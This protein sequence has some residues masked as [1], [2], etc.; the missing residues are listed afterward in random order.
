MACHA[1]VSVPASY[2]GSRTTD[3]ADSLFARSAAVYVANYGYGYGAVGEAAVCP[4]RLM[5]LFAAGVAD[6][7]TAG[8]AWRMAKQEYVATQGRFGSYDEKVPQQAIFYGLPMYRVEGAQAA[9]APLSVTAAVELQPDPRTGS[10]AVP[11]QTVATVSPSFAKRT[12]GDGSTYQVA[13]AASGPDGQPY[14][15]AEAGAIVLHGYPIQPKVITEVT[16]DGY[17]ARGA[18]IESMSSVPPVD[19]TVIDD[20]AYARAIVDLAANEPEVEPGSVIFPTAFQTVT[21]TSD[22]ATSTDRLLLFPGQLTVDGPDATQ[23]LFTDLTPTVYYVADEDDRA[24]DRTR[25]QILEST[26]GA[27]GDVIRFRVITRDK[28]ADG[29]DG[30]GV[31][32]IVVLY[33]DRTNP[34]WVGAD[35]L[36]VGATDEWVGARCARRTPAAATSCRSS[37]GPAMSA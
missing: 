30:T 1:G 28:N 36:Q 9:A 26:A 14:P 3:W 35:L 21:H 33:N 10:A 22:G 18:V 29:S 32:R 19:G 24:A 12:L 15:T 4:E 34:N 27:T 25:P 7:R 11:A 5:T 17:E 2:A 31:A 13:T 6:G 16:V 23:L 8:E 20:P 37:M